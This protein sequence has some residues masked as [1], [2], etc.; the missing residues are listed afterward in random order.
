MEFRPYYLAREWVRM[1][2]RVTIVAGDFSHLRKINPHARQ[3]FQEQNIDGIAYCWVRTG[4]YQGNGVAR[5]LT[6]F[7]F[8]GKLWLHAKRLA[9]RYKPD[10]VI[11]S[12]TYPI[13]TFACQKIA[14]LSHAKLIHE[15]H[16]M[17]PATLIEIGGMSPRHPFVQLMQW[18]ENSFC[19]NSDAVVSLLPCAKDYFVG[20][21]MNK[22]KF[23]HVPNGFDIA[24]WGDG[25]S[26][27]PSNHIKVLNELHHDG[28]FILGYAGGHAISNALT[29]LLKAAELLKDKNIAIVLVGKGAEK[30]NLQRY[31]KEHALENIYFLPAVDKICVPVVLSYMDA[32]YIGW[33]KRDLYKNFGISPNKLIDYMLSAKPILF[34]GNVANDTVHESGCGVSV[35]AEDASEIANGIAYLAG[36]TSGELEQMGSLGRE[37]AMKTYDYRILAKRFAEIME[38]INK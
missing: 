17:W 6:M 8:V 32:L 31:A 15:V 10:I 22:D 24:E 28:K 3:D 21:G 13:D 4:E 27:I 7:R 36:K 38:L 34:S 33:S 35:S 23:Y 2:H 20:H 19:R 9:A 29:Y 37:F 30:R 11:A 16:D 25:C 26:N 12:S 1:G 5:A 14:K 18:G